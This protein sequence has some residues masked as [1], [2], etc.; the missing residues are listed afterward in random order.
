MTKNFMLPSITVKVILL[1]L[2]HLK[3]HIFNSLNRDEQ[4]IWKQQETTI[5]FLTLH[6]L[7]NGMHLKILAILIGV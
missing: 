1:F 6:L 4:F 3:L 2:K 7:L 5:A